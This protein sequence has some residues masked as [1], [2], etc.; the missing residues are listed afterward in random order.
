MNKKNT[1]TYGKLIKA[2]Y[3]S[4]VYVCIFCTSLSGRLEYNSLFVG[5]GDTG[6]LQSRYGRFEDKYFVYW[7]KNP[8]PS[9]PQPRHHN[10]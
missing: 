9:N 4:Y 5:P 6:M 7:D 3:A 10:D 8:G 2:E 1:A